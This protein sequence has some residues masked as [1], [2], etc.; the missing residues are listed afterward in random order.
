MKNIFNYFSPFIISFILILLLCNSTFAQLNGNYTINP[1]AAASGT[2]YQNWASAVG[3]LVSGNRTDGGTPQ[4]A[5]VSGPVTI[6][7]YDTIYNSSVEIAAISG[8]SYTNKITFKP[9]HR[10]LSGF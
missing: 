4:G 8:T 10:C 9:I 3:D 5:G 2:N 6:T 7:V 1:I